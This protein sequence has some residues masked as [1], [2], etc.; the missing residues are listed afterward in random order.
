M[1]TPKTPHP[2]RSRRSSRIRAGLHALAAAALI[3][4]LTGCTSAVAELRASGTSGPTDG[5][6]LRIA[7]A[8]DLTPASIFG[9]VNRTSDAVLGLAYDSLVDYPHDSLEAQPAL[10]TSWEPGPDGRS[11]TL[12][13]REGVTFH[14]GKPFT[15]ADVQFSIETFADPTWSSQFQR[16]AAAV[17]G[18]DTSDPHAITLTFAHPL[19]N[20]LDLLDAV[21]ILDRDTFDQVR[22]GTGYNG[23]G[24]FTF[25]SWQ[26]GTSLT[27]ARNPGY[28]QGPAHLDAVEFAQVPDA[29]G[30]VAGLRAGQYDLVLSATPRDV[31]S[32]RQNPQFTV[33]EFTGA[34]NMPYV[35]F[36]LTNPDLQ[37]VRLRQAV[38][39]AVDR[40]RIATEIYRGAATPG[41]L[42]W[43]PS[44][45]AYDAAAAQHYRHDPQRARELVAELD[46]VPTLP[47]QFS[48][49][50]P[51]H[52]AI[53]QVV[54]QDLAEVGIPVE[55]RPTERS[56]M[57]QKLVGA[58]F[59]GLWIHGHT[60]A[61][62]QPATL[63]VSAF[64]F[65]ANSN[66]SHFDSAEY[67]QAAEAAWQVRDPDS[68]EA[69]QIYRELNK[70]LLDNVPLTDLVQTHPQFVSTNRV[71]QIDLSKRTELDLHQTY[72]EQ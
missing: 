58:E 45:P 22:E 15:S 57:Y 32:L 25:E 17:T 65:N 19:S 72:K 47:L 69:H 40:E 70:Q 27:F 44:S 50:L 28:W 51:E 33:H 56:V 54:Q 12:Q 7:T 20:V 59:D 41:S 61:Q 38:A 18:F 21:P 6:T 71:H 10:A 52:A 1:S 39:H 48:A 63:T 68:P 34:S 11:L 36:N 62:Y 37:E 23:T 9:Q 66:A 13:L 14:N 35:G 4:A 26:P 42:P 2:Y 5:G 55:L 60:Y 64:P 24:A 30:Q 29:Q 53:A 16:T 46:S 43:S 8:D 49:N 31:Q 3:L 67:R